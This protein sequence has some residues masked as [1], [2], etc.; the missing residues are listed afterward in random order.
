[1]KYI[2]AIFIVLGSSTQV[3]AQDARISRINKKKNVK[4]TPTVTKS[5]EDSILKK[6]YE[7]NKNIEELLRLRA[8]KPFIW[9]AKDKIFTGKV[10]KATL[11]NTVVSSNLSTPIL[12]KAH[13]DQGLAFDTK[14]SCFGVT[15]NKRVQTV[16]DTMITSNGEKSVSAA[17]LNLD[18][19]S[20]L[21]GHFDDKKEDMITGAII[22]DF[23]SG[24]LSASKSR[25]VTQIGEIEDASLKNQIHSGLINS[26]QRGSE[27]LL[28][29]S[30][31]LE[32]VITIEAGKTVLVYFKEA[33][34]E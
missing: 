8:T 26:A 7:Q 24:I 1:M 10:Y 16:C 4:K 21:E 33:V 20:G 19:S 17:L 22:S 31:N 3:F 9:S 15:K 6:M 11:L 28:A 34:N 25:V 5:R 30:K 13:S 2:L 29:E 27:L 23:V 12:V 32:P 18:G 14:F